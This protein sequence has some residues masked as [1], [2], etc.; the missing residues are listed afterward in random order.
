MGLVGRMCGSCVGM[1]VGV[2]GFANI[3]VIFGVFQR[4]NVSVNSAFKL[5]V[6][7]SNATVSV[8]NVTFGVQNTTF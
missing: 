8:Q 4:S 7:R 5:D 3:F 2:D 1:Y 6:R